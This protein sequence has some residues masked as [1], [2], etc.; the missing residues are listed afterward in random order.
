MQKIQIIGNV[1]QDARCQI[2]NN[3]SLIYFSVAV[4][5][6]F[7]VQG[8]T[9][10]QTTWYDCSLWR[11]SDNVSKYLTK[12][13]RVWING[14]PALKEYI[15]ASGEKKASLQIIIHDFELLSSARQSSEMPFDQNAPTEDVP[16]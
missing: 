2:V 6:K 5:D 11:D 7:K 8:E 14:K 4:N 13:T 10:E 15:N 9:K 3:R 16:Y 1:G 12:G